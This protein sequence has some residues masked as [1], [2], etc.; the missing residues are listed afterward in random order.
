MVDIS[1]G[2]QSEPKGGTLELKTPS[3]SHHN[4]PNVTDCSK[5]HVHATGLKGIYNVSNIKRN[6][7]LGGDGAQPGRKDLMSAGG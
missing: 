3:Q 2:V 4:N 7:L 5:Y 6:P 1:N